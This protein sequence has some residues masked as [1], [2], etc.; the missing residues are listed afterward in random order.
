VAARTAAARSAAA[1][2]R[3]AIPFGATSV[4]LLMHSHGN[5]HQRHAHRPDAGEDEH[6][7][8]MPHPVADAEAEG[9]YASVAWAG[10]PEGMSATPY[11]PRK[12]LWRL[13]GTQLFQALL[14]VHRAH[15]QRQVIVLNQACLSEGQARY[16][17]HT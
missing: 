15:P 2:R 6:F 16:L 4:L 10:D 11:G 12:H 1:R 3:V 13:Y 8:H 17:F 5:A 14:D 9:L 7:I